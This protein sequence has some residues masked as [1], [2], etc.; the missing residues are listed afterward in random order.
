MR[1]R[2]H[3]MM[4]GKAGNG[5]NFEALRLGIERC[6][7]EFVLGFYAEDARLSI[8]N[9]VTPRAAPFELHGKAEIAKH[10][11]AT[12]GQE[13]SH[14]VERTQGPLSH[15]SGGAIRDVDHST[16]Y[17]R[18]RDAYPIVGPTGAA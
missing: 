5:L 15:P 9:A 7:P 17:T 8:V 12:F 14:R 2:L 18:S 11:R 10:L 3:G 4:Q 6:D 13:A 1:K 16:L